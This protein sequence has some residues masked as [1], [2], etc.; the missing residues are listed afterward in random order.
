MPTCFFLAFISKRSQKKAQHLQLLTVSIQNS[1]RSL[2]GILVIKG[3]L[4]ATSICP[5]TYI[6]MYVHIHKRSNSLVSSQEWPSIADCTFWL[7]RRVYQKEIDMSQNDSAV[8]NSDKKQKIPQYTH[9]NNKVKYSA[10]QLLFSCFPRVPSF[11]VCSPQHMDL[12][13]S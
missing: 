6:C 9:L 10:L 8:Q 4:Y 13:M 2:L 5:H 11:C 1:D 12:T 7:R 3:P